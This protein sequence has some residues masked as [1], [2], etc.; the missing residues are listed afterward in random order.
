MS[1]MR[2]MEKPP[3]LRRATR[4]PILAQKAFPCSGGGLELTF[5]VWETRTDPFFFIMDGSLNLKLMAIGL[6]YILNHTH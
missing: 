3:V 4:G 2:R 1:G 5:Y 6:L